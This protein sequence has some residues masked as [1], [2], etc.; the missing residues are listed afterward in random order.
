MAVPRVEDQLDRVVGAEEVVVVARLAFGKVGQ[1]FRGSLNALV[2]RGSRVGEG[3]GAAARP[4]VGHPGGRRKGR[5]E[6]VALAR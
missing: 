6:S 5:R 4:E 2:K 1:T 3:G